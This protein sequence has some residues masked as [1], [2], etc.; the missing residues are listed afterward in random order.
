MTDTVAGG[1]PEGGVLTLRDGA[2]ETLH[3]LAPSFLGMHLMF[4]RKRHMNDCGF[5]GGHG[6]GSLFEVMGCRAPPTLAP[7][8]LA[9][10]GRLM[11]TAGAILSGLAAGAESQGVADKTLGPLPPCPLLWRLKLTAEA[12]EQ[13][14]W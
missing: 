7:S 2:V 10:G 1:G 3:A 9:T 11:V 5:K 8:L 13:A 4:L 14:P 12:M 6:G